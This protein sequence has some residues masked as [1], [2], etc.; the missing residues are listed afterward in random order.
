MSRSELT[1]RITVTDTTDSSPLCDKRVMTSAMKP[2]RQRCD[3]VQSQADGYSD[4]STFLLRA[5]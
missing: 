2:L 5:V 4:M 1:A 3:P